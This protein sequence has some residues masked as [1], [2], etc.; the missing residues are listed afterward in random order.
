MIVHHLKCGSIDQPW[1]EMVCHVLLVESDAGLVLVD[2]GFGLE[3]IAD[4]AKRIGPFRH[5][6]RTELAP[7]ETA[8]RQVEAL[9]YSADDVRHIVVT[10]FDSDHIGGIADFPEAQV[11]ATSAE[12]LGSMIAPSRRE[13]IRYRAA[14]WDHGPKVVEHEPAGEAWRGFAAAKEIDEIGPG[15]VLVSLPGHSRGHAGVAVDAGDRWILHAGDAFYHVGGV[16]GCSKIPRILRTSEA[17][18]AFDRKALR[19]NQERLA[20]L[21]QRQEPD[22]TVIC[23]HDPSMLYACQAAVGAGPTDEAR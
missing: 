22:L 2:A 16:D 9:G 18:I 20:E 1:G 11:H 21:Y 7:E 17:L 4:P 6:L 13:R 15:V 12:V 3:D 14:Q 19:A 23:A 8:R 10:H 5:F